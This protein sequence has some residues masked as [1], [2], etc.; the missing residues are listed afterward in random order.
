L[1]D[2]PILSRTC[3]GCVIEP[4]TITNMMKLM[5]AKDSLGLAAP[6][7]G[8]NARVF[9]AEWGEVF[10]GPRIRSRGPEYKTREGCLSFPGEQGIK[11]R[12]LWITLC[13][14]RYYEG[15]QAVV[16]QHELDHLNGKTIRCQDS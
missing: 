10:I 13:N 11:R 6:Q 2:D 12:S 3:D 16:I 7:V 8:I 14:D 1:P 15:L 4:E 9:V 5:H